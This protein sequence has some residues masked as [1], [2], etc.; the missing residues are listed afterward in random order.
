MNKDPHDWNPYVAGVALGLVLIATYLA[1]GFGFGASAAATRVATY[2]AYLVAPETTANNAYL[3]QYFG[4]AHI[5]DDW[6]IFEAF[7]IF[8]GGVVGAYT[9]GRI[10]VGHVEMGPRTN[11]T[12]RLMLALAGGI[13]M[14]FAARL[15]RGCTSGQA[16]SGGAVLSAG[17]WIFMV[18]VFAGGYLF[19]PVVKKAWR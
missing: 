3:A 13:I 18:A 11:A 17:S 15:A 9:A 14:G 19:A 7:G 2:G 8:I 5:L 12:T 10:R 4:A 16:L 1:M 6:M